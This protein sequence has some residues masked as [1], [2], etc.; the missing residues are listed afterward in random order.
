MKDK[1]DHSNHEFINPT[2]VEI[3]LD[4]TMIRENIKTGSGQTMCMEDIQDIVRF[5]EAGQDIILIIEVVTGIVHEVT[6]DMV[7][8]IIIAIIEGV[9]IEIKIMIGTGVGHM[10]DRIGI[11]G[12]LEV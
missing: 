7:D 11:E 8:L 9:V 4:I 1:R 3:R 2:E 10:K 12:R 6:K 5:I